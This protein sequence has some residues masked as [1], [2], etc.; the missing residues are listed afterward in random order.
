MSRQIRLSLALPA[1][2]VAASLSPLVIAQ[3]KPESM[4]RNPAANPG[5]DALYKARFD[6]LM[7]DRGFMTS[8][9]PMEPVK[10]ATPDRPLPVATPAQRT[11]APDALDKASAY[12]AASNARAFLVWR[13]GRIERADYFKGADRDTQITSKSLSKPL[14]AIA[15]GRAIALGKIRS[16]DQPMTDFIPE[17]RDT[18]KATMTLRHILDMRSGLLEQDFSPDSDN[19]LNRAYIDPDHGWQIVHNYP[20]THAPGGYYGY[21]NAVAE[22]VALVIERAT[23]VRYA[24]FVGREILQ[25]IG[26]QGGEIWVDRPG[27]LAHS[28]CCMTLPAETWLRLGVLLL[29][30]GMANG[31]RLLPKGYVDAMARGTPQNPHYGMGVWVAGPYQERRGFGAVGRPGP[32]VLHS[33]PYRDRDLFL[34]DGNSNQVVYISRATGLVALRVG[35]NPPAGAEWDNS[36]VPNLLID[37][38]AWKRGEKRPVPQPAR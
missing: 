6:A 16:V 27:G 1:A 37:G 5:W 18:P 4:R 2:L 29:D 20:L 8:Y 15:V 9:A 3:A 24:D 36:I 14:T 28:G 23:G 13:N 26:A 34:F 33:A 31:K 30:D 17:W 10:G 25:P 32:K 22:L 7:R 11:I 21:S 19:P 12:A 35:D 38:I